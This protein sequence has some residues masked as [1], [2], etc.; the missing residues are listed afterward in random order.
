MLF[1]VH[2]MINVSP[3]GARCAGPAPDPFPLHPIFEGRGVDRAADEGLQ[4][5]GR[6]PAGAA[7]AAQG[8]GRQDADRTGREVDQVA[9]R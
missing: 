3:S 5:R 7:D 1:P 6:Y 8:L 9:V 2:R 4:G